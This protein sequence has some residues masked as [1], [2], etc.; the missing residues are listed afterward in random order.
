[1]YNEIESNIYN[2]FTTITEQLGGIQEGSQVRIALADLD[3]DGLLEM[4]VGN[5]RGGLSAFKTDIPANNTV[6]VTEPK[7]VFDIQIMP[8]PAS[9]VV[10]IVTKEY[11]IARKIMLYNAA[12]QL[13]LQDSWNNNIFTL[14]VH[15]LPA[16]VYLAKIE[17]KGQIQTRK[18]VLMH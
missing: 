3:Q 9:T 14:N 2:T 7:E 18:I 4:M 13:I 12:G 11:N 6:P 16:G 8:N 10:N 15:H 1:M 17:V 5:Q